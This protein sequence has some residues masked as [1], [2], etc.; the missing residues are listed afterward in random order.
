MHGGAGTGAAWEDGNSTLGFEQRLKA[1]EKWMD[2]VL[3]QKDAKIDL[4]EAQ[5]KHRDAEFEQLVVF[6]F[7]LNSFSQRNTDNTADT[8][9]AAQQHTRSSVMVAGTTTL[10]PE[11]L[12]CTSQRRGKFP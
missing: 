4:L 5:L 12:A 3:E 6:F 7:F 8:H 1:Y 2:S 9:K 11:R 10:R